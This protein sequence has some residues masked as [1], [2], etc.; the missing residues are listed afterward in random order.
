MQFLIAY[1][2]KDKPPESYKRMSDALKRLYAVKILE[3][4]WLLTEYRETTDSLHDYL[5]PFISNDDSLIVT[6]TGSVVWHNT[7]VPLDKLG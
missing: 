4:V 2:L 3:S 5:R 7:L 1:D 6:T